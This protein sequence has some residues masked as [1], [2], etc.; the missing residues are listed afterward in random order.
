MNSAGIKIKC[1]ET[2]VGILASSPVPQKRAWNTLTAHAPD[3]PDFLGK[4][5]TGT[6]KYVVS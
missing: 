2:D 4:L 6:F 5:D 3:F 1:I